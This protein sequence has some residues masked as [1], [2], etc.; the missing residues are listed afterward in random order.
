MLAMFAHEAQIFLSVQCAIIYHIN[1]YEYGMSALNQALLCF[2]FCS[3]TPSLNPLSFSLSLSCPGLSDRE[4][5]DLQ[6]A[7]SLLHP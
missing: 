3:I 4:H 6:F 1:V 2:D 7:A 5:V